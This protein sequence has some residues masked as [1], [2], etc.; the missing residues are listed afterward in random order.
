M[1][2]CLSETYLDS[3]TPDNLLEIERYYLVHV[4]HPDN[5]FAF[6]TKSHFLFGL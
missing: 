3:A 2:L 6:T 1:I 5:M 4:D